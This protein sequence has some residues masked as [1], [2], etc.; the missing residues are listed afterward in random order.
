M[1]PFY[2][3]CSTVSRLQS[4]YEETYFSLFINELLLHKQLSE[5]RAWYRFHIERGKG[6]M[7]GE[8]TYN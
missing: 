6:S 3:W 8:Q 7:V 1:A 2:G 5:E 4:H